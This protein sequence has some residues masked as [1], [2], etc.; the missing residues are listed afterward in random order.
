MRAVPRNPYAA[1]YFFIALIKNAVLQ[2]KIWSG[3]GQVI[4]YTRAHEY[5]SQKLPTHQSNI[6][7][8]I[9]RTIFYNFVTA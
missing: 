4:I 7:Y 1:H 5:K 9:C 6:L 8:C 3:G 2:E